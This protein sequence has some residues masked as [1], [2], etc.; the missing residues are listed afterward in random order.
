MDDASYK[1]LRPT[2]S[3]PS[4]LYGL[5]KIHKKD[6]PLRPIISQIGSY[7]YNVA[8]FLVPILKPL[9]VNEYSIKDSFSFAHELLAINK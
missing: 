4:K 3:C 7:T 5:P 8:K 1:Q 9:T 2:G 6:T